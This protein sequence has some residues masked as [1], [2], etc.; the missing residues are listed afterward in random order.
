MRA[1]IRLFWLFLFLY[2]VLIFGQIKSPERYFGFRMGEDK[3]LIGWD[4]IVGY[5]KYI[6]A[7]SDRV[8]VEELGKTTL[9]KPFIVPNRDIK[10]LR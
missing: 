5:F 2:P 6:D 10:P 1:K 7:N 4:E 9:G 3:K 8:I